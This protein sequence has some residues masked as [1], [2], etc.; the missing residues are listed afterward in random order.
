MEN[1]IDVRQ[2]CEKLNLK[3]STL[4]KKIKLNNVPFVRIGGKI[5]FNPEKL[6][7]WVEM[8]SHNSC[9]IEKI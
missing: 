5:L 1:L 6:K 2:A 8:Q 9:L 3:K 4:Y 7:K